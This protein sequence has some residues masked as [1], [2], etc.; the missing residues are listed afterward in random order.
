MTSF[1]PGHILI[2]VRL[3]PVMG[4]S[5][6]LQFCGNC[7]TLSA[8]FIPLSTRAISGDAWQGSIQGTKS[9]C[10]WSG[11]A[12]Q[13]RKVTSIGMGNQQGTSGKFSILASSAADHTPMYYLCLS[14]RLSGG[15][16]VRSTNEWATQGLW[17]LP[18]LVLDFSWN[19]H[20]SLVAVCATHILHAV[21]VFRQT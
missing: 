17:S 1:S 13:P 8:I 10:E 19:D 20:R 21:S 16:K 14:S 3:H 6:V 18:E 4:Q 11:W 2:Q 7:N 5:G 9:L 15:C 12:L